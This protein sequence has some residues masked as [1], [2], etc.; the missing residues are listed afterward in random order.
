[1]VLLGRSQE[2]TCTKETPSVP[3][4]LFSAFPGE[5]ALSGKEECLP[6]PAKKTSQGS[7][8]LLRSRS[9]IGEHLH[10]F[11][12]VSSLRISLPAEI[13]NGPPQISDDTTV[14]TLS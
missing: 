1:M 14:R 5:I 4:R 7:E 9:S 12:R 11:W 6:W 13:E 2:N 3:S 8:T 10:F